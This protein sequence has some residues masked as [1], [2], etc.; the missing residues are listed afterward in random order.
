MCAQVG[1]VGNV[2]AAALDTSG[3]NT[4]IAL[5]VGGGS[6]AETPDTAGAAKVLEYL[7]FSATK[8]R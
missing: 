6:S 5:F 3:P 1:S 8:D 7:A 4:C 2:K